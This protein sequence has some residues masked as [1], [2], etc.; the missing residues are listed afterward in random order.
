MFCKGQNFEWFEFDRMNY[1]D[2]NKCDSLRW[3]V[4]CIFGAL[5]KNTLWPI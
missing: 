3:S 1:G 4:L 2:R 5:K